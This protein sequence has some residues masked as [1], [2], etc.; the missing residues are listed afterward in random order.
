MNASEVSEVL[1]RQDEQIPAP[2]CQKNVFQ[3]ARRILKAQ[4]RAAYSRSE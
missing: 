1:A 4:D 2:Q 3:L